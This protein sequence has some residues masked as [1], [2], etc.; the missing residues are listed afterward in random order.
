MLHFIVYSYTRSATLSPVDLLNDTRATDRP[1]CQLEYVDP[2]DLQV[3][4]QL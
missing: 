2:N 1:D 4:H 3:I